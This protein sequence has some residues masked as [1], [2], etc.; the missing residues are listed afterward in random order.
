MSYRDMRSELRKLRDSV[1][2]AFQRMNPSFEQCKNA[3]EDG[4]MFELLPYEMKGNRELL[5]KALES[6]PEAIQFASQ[7]LR[8]DPAI[9]TLVFTRVP[10]LIEYAAFEL[11]DTAFLLSLVA[12]SKPGDLWTISKLAWQNEPQRLQPTLFTM[13]LAMAILKKCVPDSASY[14]PAFDYFLPSH[15]T[16]IPLV[17]EA[18]AQG[19]RIYPKLTGPVQTD[20][21]VIRSVIENTIHEFE[22][23]PSESVDRNLARLA[24]LKAGKTFQYLLPEFKDDAFYLVTA[25]KTF[26]HAYR[27][28]S[29][30]LQADK[31]ITQ[32]AIEVYGSNICHASADLKG[33]LELVVQAIGNRGAALAFVRSN[34]RPLR[35]FQ[36]LSMRGLNQYEDPGI[37]RV[38]FHLT[39]GKMNRHFLEKELLMFGSALRVREEEDGKKK[40]TSFEGLK[41]LNAHG[42]FMSVF[43]K[44][45]I[46]S[47]LDL[48]PTEEIPFIKKWCDAKGITAKDLLVKATANFYKF[49]R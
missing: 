2:F 17:L 7:E 44:K 18:L 39:L 49:F 1:V 29:L 28:A 16:D 47:F 21:R 48:F 43:L 35:W 8:S 13:E 27:Y 5:I 45:K 19:N 46:A 15:F 40:V 25:L 10:A 12:E 4:K 26:P 14:N 36:V 11:I 24:V 30:R 38:S 41:K 20:E 9:I 42:P 33:D 37:D 3:C 23:V 31:E 32:Y 22:L 34:L 6:Y